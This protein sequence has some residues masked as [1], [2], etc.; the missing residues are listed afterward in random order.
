MKTVNFKY[1]LP[2]SLLAI[3]LILAFN[4][5]KEKTTSNDAEI[6]GLI[7][8]DIR[9]DCLSRPASPDPVFGYMVL[10]V[11]GNDLQ[12]QHL[13]A[14]YNCCIEYAVNY[15]IDNFNITATET[16]IA[17]SPCFC[18]CFFNLKSTVFDLQSGLYTVTLIGIGG[19]TVGTDTVTVGG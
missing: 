14:Y 12:I 11:Q 2:I 5:T 6:E 3:L 15:Q 4:C 18:E 10:E 1:N 8:Q 16:D 13:D 7:H 19:D 9:G 17:A